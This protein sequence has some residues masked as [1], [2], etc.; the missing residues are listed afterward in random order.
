[1]KNEPWWSAL[2]ILHQSL[3][4]GDKKSNAASLEGKNGDFKKRDRQKTSLKG[5][6]RKAVLEKLN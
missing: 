6:D 1:M 2:S 3:Q 5:A 4:K